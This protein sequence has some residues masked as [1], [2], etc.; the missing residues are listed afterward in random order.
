[1]RSAALSVTGRAAEGMEIDQDCD[2]VQSLLCDGAPVAV[3]VL[4]VAAVR[5]LRWCG[6]RK[7]RFGK[8]FQIAFQISNW[9]LRRLLYSMV[10]GRSSCLLLPCPEKELLVAL[11][12]EWRTCNETTAW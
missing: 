1:M 3:V 12:V 4:V 2:I 8:R 6:G 7:S 5:S 10:R 9:S 11:E